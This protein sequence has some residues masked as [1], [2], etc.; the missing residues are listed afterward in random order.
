MSTLKVNAITE[1]DGTRFP[2]GRI[3]QIVTG[4]TTSRVY[5]SSTSYQDTNLS[6]SISLTNA[7][8]NVIVI[9]SGDAQPDGG[10]MIYVTVFRGG[11]GGTDIGNGSSGI[12]TV[13]ADGN[14]VYPCTCVTRD[15]G[16][17]T[18]N[19]TEYLVKFKRGETNT[20]VYFPGN[21]G[22]NKFFIH[23]LEEEV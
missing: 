18:T 10:A 8:N 13:W 14:G 12:I 11:T 15:T 19:A 16:I 3:I 5:T 4:E 7:S 17:N 23:L 21:N 1:T 9:L 22:G 2:Y 6:A 20:N